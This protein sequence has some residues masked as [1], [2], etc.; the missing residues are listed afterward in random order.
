MSK[1]GKIVSITDA[2]KNRQKKKSETGDQTADA[3]AMI[4]PSSELDSGVPRILLVDDNEIVLEVL[5]LMLAIEK[6]G[7]ILAN[8]G[9]KAIELADQNNFDLIIMDC[10]M[11][12][13][14]GLQ[15][16]SKIRF[17]E[18]AHHSERSTIIAL[19]AYLTDKQEKLCNAAGMDDS[20][21]KPLSQN[22]LH[23]LL[24]LWLKSA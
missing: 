19:T 23:N 1:S 9:Q 4:Q 14:D 6:C 11:P 18:E 12:N 21:A 22:S 5:N 3:I 7:V 16:T 15:A 17:N 2:I 13:I 8:S 10:Q 24:Q 20:Y